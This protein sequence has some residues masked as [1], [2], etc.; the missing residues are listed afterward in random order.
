MSI[1]NF[2]FAVHS[3]GKQSDGGPLIGPIWTI[4]DWYC[5][6]IKCRFLGMNVRI[7]KFACQEC[8]PS[9]SLPLLLFFYS[10]V[11]CFLSV[12][13]RH[14]WIW[15]LTLFSSAS[16]TRRLTSLEQTVR[17]W[18]SLVFLQTRETAFTPIYSQ[19]SITVHCSSLWHQW[20]TCGV[21]VSF[22]KYHAEKHYIKKFWNCAPLPN[23]QSKK[24]KKWE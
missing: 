5:N 18:L 15:F 22:M 2:C 3:V 16:V 19:L 10:R 1:S 7:V 8:T 13:T 23:L 12:I 6:Q 14:S 17:I 21:N 20:N 24:G 4:L 11:C 9:S